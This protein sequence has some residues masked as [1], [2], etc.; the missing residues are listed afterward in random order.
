MS[1]SK[2]V[3]PVA[4]DSTSGSGLR[5][6]GFKAVGNARLLSPRTLTIY[7]TVKWD[8][9]KAGQAS[10]QPFASGSGFEVQGFRFLDLEL[11]PIP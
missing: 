5:G 7:G 4:A 8:T 9:S 2:P 11:N 3:I 6:L 1:L 10:Q